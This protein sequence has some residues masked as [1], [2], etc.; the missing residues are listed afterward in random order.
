MSEGISLQSRR[1]RGLLLASVLGSG[2]AFLDSTA[3]N[4]ALPPLQRSFHADVSLLQWIVDSYLLFLS[5]FLLVGGALGD[6][7]GRRRVF[8][9]GVA[10]FALASVGCG[11][12]PTAGLLIFARAVQ[13]VA[14]AL[15]VP[16]SLALMRGSFREEDQGPAIGMWSGLSGVTSA[17]GPIVGGWLIEVLSWRAIFFLNL[18]LAAVCLVATSRFVP[19]SRGEMGC[20]PPDLVGAALATVGLGGAVY[21]LIEGPQ[22]GL[23]PM[24]LGSGVVGVASLVG[25]VLHERRTAHPMLPLDIFRSRQFSGANATT[26]AAYAALG[27]ATFVLTL[28]LQ[29]T[30]GYSPLQAGLALTPITVL[31]L[32]LSRLAA[33]VAGRIGYRWP[34]V[35]GCLVT[36]LGLVLL[37]FVR[38]GS[39]YFSGV[40]P[41]VTV[42]G[43]GL[44]ALVAPLTTAVLGSV[45]PARSGVASG[46]NNAAAR[47]AGLLAV[48]TLP[49]V[50]GLRPGSEGSAGSGYPR[51]MLLCAALCVLG[52]LVAFATM[53]PTPSPRSERPR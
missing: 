35:M 9:I 48:A 43:L 30:M 3:V 16:G 21:A 14:A 7:Y 20:A 1:G 26:L 5:A 42:F 45:E 40:L 25:F 15:L 53:G 23:S 51:A 11:L 4:V 12:A 28:H 49:S 29:T 6:R 24:V 46:V 32:A 39:G 10:A 33:R 37:S 38:P 8:E 27:G 13:G 44:S 36:G 19:E 2:M 31:M 52:A 47:V 18:P 41:G 34:M 50:A 22:R 17:L